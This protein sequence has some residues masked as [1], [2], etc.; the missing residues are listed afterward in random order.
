MYDVQDVCKLQNAM[1]MSYTQE[2]CFVVA[3]HRTFLHMYLP[4]LVDLFHLMMTWPV[5]AAVIGTLRST[6]AFADLEDVHVDVPAS[7]DQ[8]D[9]TP[10]TSGACDGTEPAQ[11]RMKVC[12]S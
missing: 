4:K 8:A 5:C 10:S 7:S 11:K 3:T 1:Q 12:N 9:A 2:S 6:S